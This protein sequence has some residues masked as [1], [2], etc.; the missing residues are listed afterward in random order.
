MSYV[1]DEKIDEFARVFAG[2]LRRL[3]KDQ[4]IQ[5]TQSKVNEE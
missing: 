5:Q 4:Q 3:I 2:I 1:V